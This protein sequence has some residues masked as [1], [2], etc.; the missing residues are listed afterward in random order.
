MG[1]IQNRPFPLS[2]NSPLKIDF[3]G[4]QVTSDA[5]L[6]VV[7]ELDENVEDSERIRV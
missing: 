6:L 3:Q 2:F 4:S 7:R 5:G 1:E